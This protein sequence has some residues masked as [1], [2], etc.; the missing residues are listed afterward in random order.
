MSAL[1]VLQKG[2]FV[3]NPTRK[4]IQKLAVGIKLGPRFQ[5]H[6]KQCPSST[7]KPNKFKKRI[8]SLLLS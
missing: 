3:K 2:I 1:D 5:K 6:L 8:L 7:V 4:F